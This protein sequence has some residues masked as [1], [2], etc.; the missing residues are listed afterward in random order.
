MHPCIGTALC[1]NVLCGHAWA[2][3]VPSP[4]AMP[5]PEAPRLP[6]PTGQVIRT[7]SVDALFRAARDIGPEGTI[8][9]ADGHYMMPRYFEIRTNGVTLRGESGDRTRV[10]LDGAKSRHGEL[11]GITACSGVTVADL[12]VQNVMWNGIKLNTNKNVQRVTIHNCVIRNVWQRGVKAVRVPEEDRERVRPRGCRIQYCLFTNDR[13]KRFEDDPADTAERFGG[14]YIGGI[15]V[16]YPTDWVISD[17]VFVG[18]RGRTRSAR[19]AIFLWHDA[20]GCLVERNI[21]VDCDSGICL[22]N[23]HRGPGT[24]IH[25]TDCVVRNNFVTRAPENGIL[26]DY[27]QDCAIVHNTVHHPENRLKRLIRLVHDNDGL[28]V[29]NNLLSGPPMRREQIVGEIRLRGNVTRVSTDAFRDPRVG[30]LHLRGNLSGV[31]AAVE[32]LSQVTDDM[33]GDARPPR[34]TA[35]A[36]EAAPGKDQKGPTR[37]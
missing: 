37:R 27:T 12:T 23:S 9:V 18:I 35:G 4:A 1:I 10:V 25:C 31:T 2:A 20:R 6:P 14:D 24:T 30:D 33:D 36:D 15:D 5:H 17:N 7:D 22:G 3:A 19:G 26:A 32:R 8:V 13:P 21:I 34:C 28:L 11:L 29:A 16:M